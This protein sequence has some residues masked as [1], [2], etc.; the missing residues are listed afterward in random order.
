MVPRT[1][2]NTAQR[3]YD[4]SFNDVVEVL[5]GQSFARNV[6]PADVFDSLKT[7][8][9][10]YVS[11]KVFF[12]K[13]KNWYRTALLIMVLVKFDPSR[14]PLNLLVDS[15]LNGSFGPINAVPLP[16]W[17]TEKTKNGDSIVIIR[18]F[19]RNVSNVKLLPT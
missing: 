18:V 2:C 8:Q 10:E 14:R 17:W 19:H 9:M 12:L 16:G 13:R 15:S 7:K 3:Y 1:V 4:T 5:A 6:S 11:L